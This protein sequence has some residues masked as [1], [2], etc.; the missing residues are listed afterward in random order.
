MNGNENSTVLVIIVGA[1]L[2]VGIFALDLS[3]PLGVAGG[4]PYVALVL[5]SLWCPWPRYALTLAFIGTALTIVGLFYSPPGGILWVVLT[6]R[7]L[8]LFAIWVTAMFCLQQ[9]QAKESLQESNRKTEKAN[10]SLRKSE[11]LQRSLAEAL[12]FRARQQKVV[13]ELNRFALKSD[14][15]TDVMNEVVG[16]LADTLGV[17]YC[18]VLEWLPDGKTMLLRAGVGWDEGLVGRA[19]VSTEQDSQAGY[20]LLSE[21]PVIVEDL[22]TETRFSGLPLLH[23]HGVV[24]GMS[25]VIQG[26]KRPWGVLGAHSTQHKI[27]SKD[28]VGF[29]Q[30]IANLMADVIARKR[31]EEELAASETNYRQVFN[32]VNDIIV[33]HDK[34]T[35]VVLDVN[36]T[37]CQVFGYTREEARQLVIGEFSLGKPPYAQED[38][39]GWVRKAVEEGPQI[40]EWLCKKK[41]GELFWVEV[42]LKLSVI[43]GKDR[44]LA[45]VRDISERK[46]AEEERENLFTKLEA[47]NA[48]LERFT[49][50]VSH[51]L[52]SP[53]ITLKG[54]MGALKQDLANGNDKAIEGDLTHMASAADKMAQLLKELLE[55][56]RIGR[57][58]NPPKNVALGELAAEAVE[59]LEGRITQ[60][61]VQVEIAPHT[62]VLYGDRIRLLEVLQNL[63]E[64]AVKHM[65]DQPQ[66]RVEIGARQD[67]DETVCYVHDNGIGIDSGY[68]EKVFDLFEKLDSTS[69]GTGIGLALVKRIVEVHGGSI[70]V[71]SEGSGKGSTFC[72]TLPQRTDS[73]ERKM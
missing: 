56:S 47:Q 72:F 58:A 46:Q 19:A 24:S 31:V 18:N 25:V 40:F 16:R 32:S 65:G 67:G 69:E 17:E 23:D 1:V 71:E 50:T 44:I 62:P 13:A 63:I 54:Y 15:L 64:N 61:G 6:N 36:E 41:N 22:R 20:T 34:D 66:P 33:V 8:A 55:L 38:A 45:V 51:D 59:L 5:T 35:G 53:L 4:V 49:Y 37:Y 9:K 60:G 27:F 11:A 30:A 57:V 28:D 3:L 52:K 70:W 10:Q 14:D 7:M 39:A 43:G 73:I 48:E 21:Q 29:L 2:A 26:P 12:E 42:N 68:H